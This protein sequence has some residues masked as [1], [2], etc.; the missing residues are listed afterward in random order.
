M[1]GSLH[2][3]LSSLFVCKACCVKYNM[4]STSCDFSHSNQSLLPSPTILS[5]STYSRPS[6]IPIYWFVFEQWV[7]SRKLF[8]SW[9]FSAQISSHNLILDPEP[10]CHTTLESNQV[11]ASHVSHTWHKSFH[12]LD[13]CFFRLDKFKFRFLPKSYFDSKTSFY[14]PTSNKP[15]LHLCFDNKALL[16]R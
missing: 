12:H 6:T 1:C 13:L 5:H 11:L 3:H 10:T 14:R 7:V 8:L 4:K 9:I 16:K 2:N 15:K